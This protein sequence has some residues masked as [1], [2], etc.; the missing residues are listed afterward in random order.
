MCSAARQVGKLKAT[1]GGSDVSSSMR[2][3]DIG[4]GMTVGHVMS[5]PRTTQ[6]EHRVYSIV[7]SFYC[8]LIFACLCCLHPCIVRST[9]LADI[10]R[11]LLDKCVIVF[12]D[13]ILVYSETE[14]QQYKD[15]SAVFNI[16][17]QQKLYIK[18]CKCEFFKAELEFLGHIV[19][20]GV[21]K[22]SKDK[23]DT[24]LKWPPLKSVADVRCFLGLCNYYRKFI[25]EFSQLAAPLTDLLNDGRDIV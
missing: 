10:K 8:S 18:M 23:V 19:G 16:L 13:D 7:P 6:I 17:R 21:I 3:G 1:F 11:P 5:A 12:I 2:R 14:E 15:V 25:Q 20:N 22:M 9:L 24:I 4:V